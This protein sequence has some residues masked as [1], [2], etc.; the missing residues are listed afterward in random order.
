M[1]RYFVDANGNYIGGFVGAEPPAG[2][3]EI[4]APPTHGWMVRD[5][6]SGTWSMPPDKQ[7]LLDAMQ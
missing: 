3:V 7:A 2:S 1:T 6:A 4:D 5:M